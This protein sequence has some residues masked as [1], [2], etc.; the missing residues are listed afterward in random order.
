MERRCRAPSLLGFR[1]P[2]KKVNS[3]SLCAHGNLPE[4]K[5]ERERKN[6]SGRLSLGEMGLQLYFQKGLLYPELHI[7][8]SER[9]KVMQ[10]QLNIPS[11]LPLTKPGHFLHN[12][13]QKRV[14]CYVHYLLALW[15]VNILWLFLDKVWSTRKPDFPLSFQFAVPLRKQSYIL[16]KQRCS[17]LQQRKYLLTQ[18]FYV[19]NTKATACFSCIPTI[20]ANA[21]PAAHWVKDK[22]TWQQ[23]LAQQCSIILIK[24]F[25]FNNSK[26]RL[27]VL[28][29][30]MYVSYKSVDK[31]AKQA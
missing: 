3:E 4:K 16:M 15:P 31:T 24:L 26:V 8:R 11:V 20:L 21:L 6:V 28:W 27:G 10:N 19:A 12:F 17:G 7:S 23:T 22:E 9:Y 29:T 1:C 13:P 5:R 30:I 2:G 25:F 18:G 14:L